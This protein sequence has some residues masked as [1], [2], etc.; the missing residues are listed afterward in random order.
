MDDYATILTTTVSLRSTV[1]YQTIRIKAKYHAFST[2]LSIT[3]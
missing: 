1:T 2:W 3:R